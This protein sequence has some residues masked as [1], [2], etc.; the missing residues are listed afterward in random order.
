MFENT[1]F[2]GRGATVNSNQFNKIICFFIKADYGPL[3]RV[4]WID[5]KQLLL[6]LVLCS[7]DL[8]CGSYF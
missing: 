7:Y 8:F 2:V 1:A 4:F 6:F 5:V 3:L